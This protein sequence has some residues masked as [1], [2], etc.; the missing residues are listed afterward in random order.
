MWQVLGFGPLPAVLATHSPGRAG[1]TE[2]S[3]AGVSSARLV[4]RE[5]LVWPW[6]ERVSTVLACLTKGSVRGLHRP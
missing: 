2:A 4:S 3:E 6:K 5:C 1:V